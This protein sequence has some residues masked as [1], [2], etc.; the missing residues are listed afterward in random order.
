M[1][2]RGP[3]SLTE[4]ERDALLSELPPTAD[5]DE[6]ED[7]EERRRMGS[8][9]DVRERLVKVE[10]CNEQ[11]GSIVFSTDE[12][13][14]ILDHLGPPCEKLGSLQQKIGELRRHLLA[15]AAN[16]CNCGKD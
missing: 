15:G 2:N 4:A 16:E 3:L 5:L 1:P 12:I 14:C 8:M 11:E 10:C 9:N 13:D 6:A 7:A